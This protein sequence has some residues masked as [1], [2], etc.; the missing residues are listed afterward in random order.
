M[1]R[2]IA[3]IE[4]GTS[5]IV[6]VIAQNNGARRLDIVG[7]GTVPYDG[8]MDGDW[9]TPRQMVQRVHDSVA[10]AE[11]EAGMRIQEIYVGV[12]GEFVHV[13]SCDVE[14]DVP[15]GNIDDNV[16][17]AL[18]DQAAD[19][20]DLAGSGCMVLH[21]SPAWY[22]VDG[23]KRTMAPKGAGSR[24]KGR[25]SFIVA[26]SVFIEDV[27][28][29]MGVLKISILGFLS[30]SLGEALLL[31]PDEDRD[32]GSVLID[33]GYLSTELSLIEGDAIVYHA[34]LPMGGGHVTARLAEDLR[35]PMR[36]AEEIKRKYVFNPDEYDR[37]SF[38]EVT[39]DAGKRM[40][41]P[42]E[43]VSQSVEDCFK[44]LTSMIDMTLRNDVGQ[45]MTAR[46]QVY[47][48][49]GGIAMMQG[50]KDFLSGQIGY[51]VKMAVAKSS[52]LNSPVYG[53]ALG[54][55]DLTFNALEGNEGQNEQGLNKVKNFFKG[56]N[57]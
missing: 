9:N 4:F 55:A 53:A 46:S 21:R 5:K 34:I 12:P 41:F 16:L 37:D 10:A 20:L 22:S 32:R 36:A 8:Y 17:N 7:S 54:L 25:V 35:I 48:T 30:P 26:E 51:P 3:A 50:G 38:S 29:M 2:Q 43:I 40:T 57:A 15:E 27:S 44:E 45:L 39:D 13:R 11:M 14:M 24:I 28:E 47:L 49:G 42:R 23:G 56:R 18:M 33:C 52:E 31:I 6:T 19:E 1:K